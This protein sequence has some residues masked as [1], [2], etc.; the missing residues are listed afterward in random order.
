MDTKHLYI[1]YEMSPAPPA[2][3]GWEKYEAL[4]VA[5]WQSLLAGGDRA[6]CRGFAI[7]L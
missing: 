5:Q 7:S 6:T 4:A 3:T 2:I 1:T